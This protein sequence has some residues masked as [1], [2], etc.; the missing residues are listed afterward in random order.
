[1]LFRSESC[2]ALLAISKQT[3][4]LN[5]CVLGPELA[6]EKVIKYV[7]HG[8]NEKF[9]FPITKEHPEYLA[10]QEFK[11]QIFEGKE[12]EFVLLYNARNIRRKCVPDLMLAWKIFVDELPE[13]KA[14]KCA[15]MLHTH[16]VDENGTD[17]GVVCDYLFDS[18]PK[19]NIVFTPPGLG[20]EQMS[21]LYNMSDTQILLTSNEGWGLSLTEAI[22]VGNPIIANVTG[23]M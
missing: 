1:M 8:I 22:L 21:W 15:F 20:P 9:F 2:D 23:G 12:Y 14:K 4:N 3:E 16:V 6:D 11:K 17:L 7:P 10:L 13:E 5:H 18:N 19:Y